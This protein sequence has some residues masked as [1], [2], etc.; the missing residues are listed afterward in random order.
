MGVTKSPNYLQPL[1][2]ECSISY[3]PEGAVRQGVG[4]GNRKVLQVIP[5][6]G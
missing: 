5:H 2:L 1:G 4:E 6:V 3:I